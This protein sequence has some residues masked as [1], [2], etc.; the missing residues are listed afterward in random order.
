LLL[1][2]LL[3]LLLLLVCLF[4]VQEQALKLFKREY[5]VGDPQ[6]LEDFTV[7]MKALTEVWGGVGG[8]RHATQAEPPVLPPVPWR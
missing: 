1:L 8:S 4:V 7:A 6:K 3:L 5:V 2:P